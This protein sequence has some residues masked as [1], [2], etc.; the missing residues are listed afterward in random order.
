M[1]LPS[2]PIISLL[3]VKLIKTE[4]SEQLSE[5]FHSGPVEINLM[6]R[7]NY[8]DP[9]AVALEDYRAWFK[10]HGKQFPGNLTD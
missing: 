6:P 5:Q 2:C 7:F 3:K 10:L 8:S 4:L 1:L 9:S